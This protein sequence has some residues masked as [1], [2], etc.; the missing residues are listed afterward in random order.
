MISFLSHALRNRFDISGWLREHESLQKLLRENQ[1][2]QL[3]LC[4]TM[5]VIVGAMTVLL[6]H[7]VVLLHG[8]TFMLAPGEH[9][10]NAS[11]IN[12]LRIICVPVLGGVV[13]GLFFMLLAKINLREIVDPIEANAIHGGR[14]SLRQSLALLASTLFSNTSGASLGME[15]GYTQI[16]AGLSSWIGKRLNLRRE[17]MRILVA[18]GAGAAISAAFNAPMAGAFYGFELVLGGYTAAALPQVAVCTIAATLCMRLFSNGEPIFSLPLDVPTIHLGLYP[19]FILIGLLSGVVGIGTMKLVTFFEHTFRRLAM[20]DWLRPALGGLALALLAL[21]FPQ[22]L[23]SG[24]G[25]IDN[26]LHHS[27]PFFALMG[28]LAAKMTASAVSIGSGFRGGLFSSSLFL[29]CI[30]GQLFG[31]LSGASSAEPSALIDTFM[32]VGIGGVS[33]SIVGA[34]VTIM[35]LVLEMSGNFSATVAVLVGILFATVVTRY[36]F[37]YSFSTWRFHL[38]GLRITGAQDIGWV[39]ELTMATL[40]QPGTQTVP[41]TMTLAALRVLI[42]A[43]SGKPAFIVDPEGRYIGV[44]DITTIHRTDLNEKVDSIQAGDIAKAKDCFLLPRDNIRRSLEL[45]SSSQQEDLPVLDSADKR[46]VIGQV[47]ESRMLRRYAQ[48]LEARNLA[49]SGAATPV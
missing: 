23:G 49:H 22:V 11:Y 48:E 3:V 47:S 35:L 44:A 19:V 6:H 36:C 43:E 42:P 46:R 26:H 41:S 15:A 25:A 27:W 9:L 4:M 37:G 2:V 10:S 21:A 30:L 39:N 7:L 29:G 32:L 14:M 40:M 33:A 38:R 20:P 8:A 18:A 16:G 28:L 31:V 24:E 45:F 34:P 12:T 1:P 17:D 5:G 13:T